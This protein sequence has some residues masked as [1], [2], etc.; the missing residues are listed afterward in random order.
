[1]RGAR[2]TRV[3]NLYAP[4]LACKQTARTGSSAG[5]SAACRVRLLSLSPSFGM[6]GKQA[7]RIAGSTSSCRRTCPAIKINW[8]QEGTRQT[9]GKTVEAGSSDEKTAFF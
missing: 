2:R 5:L 1:M 8:N 4:V 3:L 7:L 9:R 6:R